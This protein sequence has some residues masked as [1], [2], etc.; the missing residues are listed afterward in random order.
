MRTKHIFVAALDVGEILPFAIKKMKTLQ[1]GIREQERALAQLAAFIGLLE[2]KYKQKIYYMGLDVIQE[3]TYERFIF[4]K[5]GFFEIMMETPLALNAHFIEKKHADRFCT[6][7]KTTLRELLPLS[8]ISDMFLESI[9]VEDE[10]S[11]SLT[12]KA[13]DEMKDIRN[14]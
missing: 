9:K 8:P 7:L 1:E 4:E 3:K 6:A 5:E 11:Q 12:Y 10:N 13:W 14:K 2:S